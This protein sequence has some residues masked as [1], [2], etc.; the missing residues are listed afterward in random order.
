MRI[1]LF[2]WEAVYALPVGGVA[3]HVSEL[4]S[5]FQRA[6][7][8]VHV[9]TRLG[10][11]QR[12]YDPIFGVHYHRCPHAPQP[13]FRE[14]VAGWAQSCA[15]YF[16]EAARQY[17]DFDLMHGH[18]WLGA[19]ALLRLREEFGGQQAVTF[20]TTEWGRSGAWPQQGES[21]LIADLE[22]SAQ[23]AADVVLA[24]SQGVRRELDAL[25]HVPDWKLAVVP[26][27]IAL[28]PFDRE[29][30]DPG[31]AKQAVG[32]DPMAPTVLFVGALTF[33]KGP[34]LLVQAAPEVLKHYPAARFLLVGEGDLRPHLEREAQSLKTETGPAVTFLGWRAGREQLDL[35]RACDLVCLP[36]RVDAFGAAA[37]SAWAAAK[38]VIV[39]AG[40]GA[41]E[42]I[43]DGTNGRVV[44]PTPAAV[45]AA[46]GEGFA[47]FDRLRWQGRNGRV[48]AETAFTWDCVA[49]R[50]LETCARSRRLASVPATGR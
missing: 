50:V 5:A 23:R 4:A 19:A 38:P 20:H 11:G 9:F 25:Y 12:L 39:C 6:G 18:D 35:Y 22:D 43:L 32:V 49:G 34:D 40:T 21:K 26:H 15:H 30:F 27:G 8:E 24:V 37:L 29:P 3:V 42:F 46:I 28:A 13:V 1:A 44:E 33:R 41:G 36:A 31:Q 48:A 47:D 45:A 16:G 17:G 2:S 14:E 10:P 7:H